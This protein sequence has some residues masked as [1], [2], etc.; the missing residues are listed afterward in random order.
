LEDRLG[1]FRKILPLNVVL[2]ACCVSAYAQT[3]DL[4]GQ[5]SGWVTVKRDDAQVG[6]RYI[7]ELSFTKQ[8]W[9]TYE[10]SAEAAVRAQWF[11]CYDDEW[12]HIE[13]DTDVDSYRLWVRLASSQYAAFRIYPSM[14]IR[15]PHFARRNRHLGTSAK[16][17]F[18]FVTG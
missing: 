10:I 7:P 2:L 18:P 8:I 17:D 6:L 12:D 4:S 15:K 13:S 1:R 16:L 3:V 9:E 14:V 11:S 5:V